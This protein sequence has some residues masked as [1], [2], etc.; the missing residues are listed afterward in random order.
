MGD[1]NA[2]AVH[3][4]SSDE[5]HWVDGRPSVYMYVGRNQGFIFYFHFQGNSQG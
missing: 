4:V 3:R 5:W 1:S 2:P